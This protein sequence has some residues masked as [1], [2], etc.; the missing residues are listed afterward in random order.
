MT[1]IKLKSPLDLE[2]AGVVL[3]EERTNVVNISK[4]KLDEVYG[5]NAHT[6]NRIEK[7]NPVIISQFMKYCDSL[8]FEL[9]LEKKKG[10][11]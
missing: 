7:G 9:Y 11:K 6:L 5:I 2:L 1:K 4:K 10:K 8:G 3:C